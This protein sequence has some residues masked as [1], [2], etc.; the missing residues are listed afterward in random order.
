MKTPLFLLTC[1]LILL[2]CSEEKAQDTLEK[3]ASLGKE[4]EI[5]DTIM[6]LDQ[7]S[8]FQNSPNDP[9][10]TSNQENLRALHEYLKREQY[11]GAP[12]IQE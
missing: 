5:L 8:T 4:S 3:K 9:L 11:G 12:L 6:K 7:D 10:D 2:S 1:L